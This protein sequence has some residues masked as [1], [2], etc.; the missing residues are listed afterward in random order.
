M[1]AMNG[2]G[3]VVRYDLDENEYDEMEALDPFRSEIVERLKV[4]IDPY[5]IAFVKR[6]FEYILHHVIETVSRRVIAGLQ[7]LK[8]L[9][10]VLNKV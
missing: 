9:Y 3:S 2:A 8:M 7:T 1:D 4:I 5:R 6:N 10:P